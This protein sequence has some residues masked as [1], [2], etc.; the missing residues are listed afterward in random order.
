MSDSIPSTYPNGWWFYWCFRTS[1]YKPY[2]VDDALAYMQDESE[3]FSEDWQDL[4]REQVRQM[5]IRFT[6]ERHPT[7]R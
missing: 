6:R 2:T 3:T 4:T 1:D 5:E 7:A